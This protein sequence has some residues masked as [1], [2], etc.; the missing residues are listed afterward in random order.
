MAW[1]RKSDTSGEQFKFENKGQQ[2][3]GYYLGSVDHEGDYGPTKKHLFKTQEGVKVVF[4]QKHLTDLLAGETVG[5][6]MRVTFSDTKK[7]KKGNP[8]KIYTL[9]VDPDQRLDAVELVDAAESAD[10]GT[11][12]DAEETVEE[13][14]TAAARPAPRATSPSA[15]NISKVNALLASRKSA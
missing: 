13:I 12:D 14:R 5:V 3:T 11:N 9:D 4:G 6:L 15:A 7:G 8:M 1:N 10:E 2:L